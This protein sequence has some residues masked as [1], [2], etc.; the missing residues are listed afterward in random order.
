MH[1]RIALVASSLLMFASFVRAQDA[2][3]HA[4]RRRNRRTSPRPKVNAR[5][6]RPTR[7]S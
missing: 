5:P 1:R 4:P 3:P 2:K 7:S 6:A